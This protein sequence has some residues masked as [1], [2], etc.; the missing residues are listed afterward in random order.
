MSEECK[1]CN[2]SVLFVKKYRIY[3]KKGGTFVA[4]EYCLQKY[5][6]QE[7]YSEVS[8]YAE[9]LKSLGAKT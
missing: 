1:W 6:Q 2:G 4:C 9:L 3:S 8:P 7:D 5:G